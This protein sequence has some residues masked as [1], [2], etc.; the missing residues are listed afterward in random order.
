[1]K[2]KIRIYGIHA[3]TAIL[4]D[5][6]YQNINVRTANKN[7]LV[8]LQRKF[9][10]IASKIKLVSKEEIDR[11]VEKENININHQGIMLE[12]NDI[13]EY[14]IEDV[15]EQTSHKPNATIVCLDQLQDPQNIGSIIR[16]SLAFSADAVI[17]PE[18]NSASIGAALIKAACGAIGKIP[19]I[20]VTNL[21]Q[22]IQTLQQNGYWCY[23]LS[24]KASHDITQHSFAE[25]SLIVIGSEHKGIRPLVQ[26]QCDTLV[27]ISIN[28]QKMSSI[29]AGHAA[30]IALFHRY[31]TIKN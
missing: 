3:C 1:M 4:E 2:R 25:K 30:A 21:S 5:K 10:N 28:H 18:K 24:E 20:Q 7:L 29:N 27:A 6:I 9:S 31:S 17:V 15:I 26:K 13:P 19:V 8:D 12:I 16:T 14:T 22:T 23:G 11:T